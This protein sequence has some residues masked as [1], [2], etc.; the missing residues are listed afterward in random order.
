M[1]AGEIPV[2]R[3]QGGASRAAHAR[4]SDDARAPLQVR[5]ALSG[6][7][8]NPLQVRVALLIPVLK[9]GLREGVIGGIDTGTVEHVVQPAKFL[10][11]GGY[12]RL[13]IRLRANIDFLCESR[14]IWDF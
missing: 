3:L 14:G 12:E 7:E 8:E 1:G 4:D 9:G 6:D 13:H 10:Q 5:Q 11:N 2:N